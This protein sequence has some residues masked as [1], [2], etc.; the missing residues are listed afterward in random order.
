VGA[1]EYD[2][3][4]VDTL[5]FALVAPAGT[6]TVPATVATGELLANPITARQ[7]VLRHRGATASRSSVTRSWRA[8][9]DPLMARGVLWRG[10]D[11]ERGT[12]KERRTEEESTEHQTLFTRPRE[13]L[14]RRRAFAA[15]PCQRRPPKH[16]P[17]SK[18][19]K[20]IYV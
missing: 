9:R 5:T 8:G 15:T 13:A 3:W 6:I 20:H 11:D 7:R 12:D 4:L 10:T 18:E 19:R 16:Y 1:R 17:Y 14:R 2:T